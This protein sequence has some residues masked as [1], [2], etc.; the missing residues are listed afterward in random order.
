MPFVIVVQPDTL[1]K[2]ETGLYYSGPPLI[3]LES[4]TAFEHEV[5]HYLLDYATGNPDKNHAG[6][7]WRCSALP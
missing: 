7:A 1:P 5:V 4:D 2:L 3:V 6:Q